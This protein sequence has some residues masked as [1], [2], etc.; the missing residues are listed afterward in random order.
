MQLA[1][2]MVAVLSWRLEIDLS[3]KPVTFFNHSR[4]ACYQGD[5]IDETLNAFRTADD[6]IRMVAGNGGSGPCSFIGATLGTLKRDCAT[7][8]VIKSRN[9]YTGPGDYPH[10]MWL[11]VRRPLAAW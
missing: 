10:N 8:P 11:P 5:V 9:N 3:V 4:D 7:G 2:T 6:Q 1:A